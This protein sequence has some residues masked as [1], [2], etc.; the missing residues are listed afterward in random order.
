MINTNVWER[1][2]E[3][4]FVQQIFIPFTSKLFDAMEKLRANDAVV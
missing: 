2:F 1:K 3:V 4:L